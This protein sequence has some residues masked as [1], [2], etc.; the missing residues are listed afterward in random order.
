MGIFKVRLGVD[1]GAKDTHKRFTIK[2]PANDKL[3]AAIQAERIGD[4]MVQDPLT[5]YTHAVSVRE[6]PGPKPIKIMA[7]AMA[8]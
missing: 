7:M 1:H 2:V 5:E 3:S 8:V 4:G 6:M